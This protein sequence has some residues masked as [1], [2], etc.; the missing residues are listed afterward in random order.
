MLLICNYKCA[1]ALLEAYCQKEKVF[2][3]KTNTRNLKE[4]PPKNVIFLSSSLQMAEE[5]N[6][7]RKLRCLFRVTHN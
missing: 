5:F 7:E 3:K 4:F 1:D 2:L 6:S